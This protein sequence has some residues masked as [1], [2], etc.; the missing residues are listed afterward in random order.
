MNKRRF[1]YISLM[2]L[3]LIVA[4]AGWFVKDYLGN[5]AR[6]EILGESRASILTSVYLCVLYDHSHRRGR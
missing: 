4:V 2:I 5:K 3:L 1:I 6:Q